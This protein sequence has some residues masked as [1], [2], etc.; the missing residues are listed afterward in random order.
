MKVEKV[1]VCSCDKPV[2]TTCYWCDACG[3]LVKNTLS[4]TT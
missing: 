4:T 3:L 1:P 2:V